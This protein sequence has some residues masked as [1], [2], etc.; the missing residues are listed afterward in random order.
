[1][2]CMIQKGNDTGK[3]ALEELPVIRKEDVHAAG[4]NINAKHYS[5]DKV[6]ISFTLV[7]TGKPLTDNFTTGPSG[8]F[9]SFLSTSDML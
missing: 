5:V 9:N 2:G 7:L 3:P 1:M 4:G 6:V 8:K